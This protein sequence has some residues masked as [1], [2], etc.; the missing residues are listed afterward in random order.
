[1]TLLALAVSGRGVVDPDEPAV[2]ADDEGFLR[3]RAAFETTRVYGGKAFRLDEHLDR[4]A[5]SAARL[6]LPPFDRVLF[7][8]LTA[9]ALAA[10]GQP[11]CFVRLYLTPGREGRE[12]PVALV[13]VESLPP[14]LEETRA[15]GLRVI[16]LP[17]GQEPS[18][19]GGVKSTSY[20]LNMVAVDEARKRG[21]DDAV[22]LGPQGVV[23]EGPTT[24]IWWRRDRVLC[25]PALELGILQGV[26]RGTLI[27]LAADRGYQV[28]LGVYPLAELKSAD[29]AFTSSA[30]REVMP[31]VA[32]DGRPIGDGAPGSA[33]RELQ[34]ELRRCASS[35]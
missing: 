31:V 34:D 13:L 20:A 14:E 9:Q 21:C 19:L 1:V 30:V 16:S 17:L 27:G 2:F 3:G 29:E 35:S 33:A 22:F 12:E 18:L 7:A 26:T 8:E 24:N 11:D 25:T 4:F 5:N 28:E 32:V 10:A 6:N 23:L 15:R